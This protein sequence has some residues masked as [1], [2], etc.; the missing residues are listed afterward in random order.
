MTIA[1]CFVTP[2]G[3][4][5]GADSTTTIEVLDSSGN[6]TSHYFDHAQKIFEIGEE[7]T[8][9]VVTWGL[10]AFGS[11]S[12]RTIFA[13]LGDDLRDGSFPNFLDLINGFIQDYWEAYT[14]E[15]ASVIQTVQTLKGKAC[16]SEAE[17]SE[18]AN[19]VSRFTVGFCIGGRLPNSRDQSAFEIVFE[20]SMNAPPTPR[21]IAIGRPTFWGVRNMISRVIY[22]IDANLLTRIADGPFWTGS[23]Q[24]LLDTVEPFVLRLAENLPIREAIDYIHAGISTTSKG[25]KFSHLPPVCGGPIEIATITTDRRFRW[26]TH[27][28]LGEAIPQQ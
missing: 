20:P 5:F 23:T 27:K 21:E 19:M 28:T 7:S 4:V 2:S 11:V 8:V 18:L 10:G 12:Y 16:P 13:K 25:L 17:N 6:V 1:A 26:V 15:L 24:D 9:A 14:R 3:V 22:G